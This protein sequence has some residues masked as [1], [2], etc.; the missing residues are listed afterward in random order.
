MLADRSKLSSKRLHPE[1]DSD[2][3]THTQPNTGYY[4]GT[5]MEEE[6]EGLQA[7]KEI[8]TPQ[9]DQESTNL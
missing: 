6:K 3:C 7:P 2:R 5:L 4:F 1:A 9:E 8:G